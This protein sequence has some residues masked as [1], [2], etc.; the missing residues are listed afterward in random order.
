MCVFVLFKIKVHITC[1]RANLLTHHHK[2]S[3]ILQKQVYLQGKVQAKRQVKHVQMISL[4]MCYIFRTQ[5]SP[6]IQSYRIYSK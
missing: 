6:M 1:Y 2:G 4:W 5:V 3:S